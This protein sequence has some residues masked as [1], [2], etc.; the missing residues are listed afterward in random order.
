MDVDQAVE[1]ARVAVMVTLLLSVPIM[2]VATLSGLLISIAQAVT[3]IQDQTLS[4]V[5]KIILMLITA[6]LLLPW[7]IS[8]TVEYSEDLYNDIP[9]MF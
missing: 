5:P 1:L 9:G 4:F 8:V 7:S 3:Q 6:L 2:A